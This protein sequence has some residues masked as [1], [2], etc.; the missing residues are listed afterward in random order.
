[1]SLYLLNDPRILKIY[2][3]ITSIHIQQLVKWFSRINLGKPV[4]ENTK[5]KILNTTKMYRTQKLYQW[6]NIKNFAFILLMKFELDFNRTFRSLYTV[7]SWKVK[8][9][10]IHKAM[11]SWISFLRDVL[12]LCSY[13]S[14]THNITLFSKLQISAHYYFWYSSWILK[15]IVPIT[16]KYYNDYWMKEFLHQLPIFVRP[17]FVLQT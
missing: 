7:Q 12:V 16:S 14:F 5:G 2:D 11:C 6:L 13:I 10:L 3:Q 4:S 1:M 8:F 15:K 17:Y 9:S